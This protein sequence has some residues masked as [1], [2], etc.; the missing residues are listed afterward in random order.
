MSP[1]FTYMYGPTPTG[2]P[3]SDFYQSIVTR[4]SAN[5]FAGEVTPLR[6]SFLENINQVQNHRI[7]LEPRSQPSWGQGPYS[8]CSLNLPRVTCSRPTC[9]LFLGRLGD[10]LNNPIIFKPLLMTGTFPIYHIAW[11]WI[12]FGKT[13]IN[14]FRDLQ[15]FYRTMYGRHSDLESIY[16]TKSLNQQNVQ[17]DLEGIDPISWQIEIELQ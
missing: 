10:C 8:M 16:W 13:I 17:I 6:L 9:R 2:Q 7:H 3:H 4:A 12:Y 15:G 11:F 14:I 1:F 5:G